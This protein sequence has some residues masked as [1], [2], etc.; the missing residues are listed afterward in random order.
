MELIKYL[1]KEKKKL[2]EVAS[3]NH[4]PEIRDA[5]RGKAD[6]YGSVIDWLKNGTDPAEIVSMLTAIGEE[7]QRLTV[8]SFKDF[9]SIGRRQAAFTLI[10][11]LRED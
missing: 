1:K 7:L 11:I 2:E 6:L 9:Y 3:K 8:V 4:R 10:R 5:W